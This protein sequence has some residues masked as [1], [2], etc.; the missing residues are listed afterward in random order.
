MPSSLSKI[1]PSLDVDEVKNSVT[2]RVASIAQKG[3]DILVNLGFKVV[4]EK[5]YITPVEVDLLAFANGAEQV[6]PLQDIVDQGTSFLRSA[7]GFIKID[8]FNATMMA[9]LSD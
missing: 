8:L 4:D 3:N 5:R 7:R 9:S 2:A 1:D 6:S